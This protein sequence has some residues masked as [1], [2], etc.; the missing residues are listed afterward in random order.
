MPDSRVQ[1]LVYS[2]SD[3][4]GSEGEPPPFL[5]VEWPAQIL[6]VDGLDSRADAP[7]AF[8]EAY[9][10][11]YSK[12]LAAED[13]RFFGPCLASAN[14][15][16]LPDTEEWEAACVADKVYR[17][18]APTEEEVKAAFVPYFDAGYTAVYPGAFAAPLTDDNFDWTYNP[19]GR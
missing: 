7:A 13:F 8:V 11:R 15:R 12:Q 19:G 18:T 10:E 6:R 16:W 9:N 14:I 2:Q 4:S 3:Q 5:A 17:L 1:V